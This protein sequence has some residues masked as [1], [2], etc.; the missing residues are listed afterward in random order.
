MSKEYDAVR[1]VLTSPK[2][3]GRTAPYIHDDDFDFS[4]L[5]REAETMSVGEALLVRIGHELWHAEKRAGL[6]ELVRRL[7]KLNFERVLEAL[8]MARGAR[9]WDQTMWEVAA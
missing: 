1:H 6:W 3:A 5:A 7:D 2:I 8:Q 4:G 9:A